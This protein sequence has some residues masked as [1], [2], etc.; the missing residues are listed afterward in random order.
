MD[1]ISIELGDRKLQ[2]GSGAYILNVPIVAVRILQL[3][4]G[5]IMKWHLVGDVLS[6]R[7][8]AKDTQNNDLDIE[9][10]S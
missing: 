6:I 4:A 9:P 10:S 8:V 7:R 1:Q 5:D 3:E 2:L